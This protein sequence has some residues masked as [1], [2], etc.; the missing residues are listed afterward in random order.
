MERF[1]LY[2]SWALVGISCLLQCIAL[3]TGFNR[4]NYPVVFGACEMALIGLLLVNGYLIYLYVRS[5]GDNPGSV[6]IAK[7][8]L[9]SLA[10]CACGDWLNRNFPQQFYQYDSVIEHSYLADSVWFFFP[11]YSVMLL[12]IYRIVR[13]KMGI[14]KCGAMALFAVVPG[15]FAFLD[16]V[17]SDSALY[18]RWI[19]GSYAVLISL[20]LAAGMALLIAFPWR[21]SR[22]LAIA[23]GLAVVADAIIGNFW[24]FRDGFYPQVAAANW[25]VYFVSQAMLQRLPLLSLSCAGEGPLSESDSE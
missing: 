3:L 4:V 14:S 8:C 7:L 6:V 22:W 1:T 15:L 12:A 13:P 16:M 11:G 20:M 19:T 10:L 17:N 2:V 23:A 5:R 21:Q 24:L 18:I 9:L 25:V